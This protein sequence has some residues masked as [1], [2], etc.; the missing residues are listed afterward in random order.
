M[1][2]NASSFFTQGVG[3][4]LEFNGKNVN[5]FVH[6]YDF[7]KEDFADCFIDCPDPVIAAAPLPIEF[8][9]ED[10]PEQA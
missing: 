1:V 9:E 2:K 3:S 8:C 6:H 4:E 5:D 10:G 7:D